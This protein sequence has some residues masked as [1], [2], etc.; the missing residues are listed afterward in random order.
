MAKRGQIKIKAKVTAKRTV[1]LE[2]RIQTNYTQPQII[3]QPQQTVSTAPAQKALN[4]F[5]N[6]VQKAQRQLSAATRRRSISSG[7]YSRPVEDLFHTL[8]ER[9]KPEEL[10]SSAMYDVFISHASED[11]KDF[12]EPLVEKL[13]NAGI[14]VWYDTLSMEWGKSLRE[15]IDNGI[16]HSK[17]AI[18]V[19]SKHFF[20]KKWPQRE[21]DGILSKETVSGST[22]L[23]IWHN[24]TYEE[25][26]ELSPTMSGLFAYSTDKY[27][28]DDICK[29]L[30]LVLDKEVV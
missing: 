6:Q 13:Q 17:F 8:D 29:A 20:A 30:E 3:Y 15:Q 9:R 4:D 28:I 27:S 2:Q 26:Y 14:R 22:P 1:R 24:I 11:K 21:L 18:L 19:F 5:G 10:E 23:P 25:L 16:K 12:V 7:V